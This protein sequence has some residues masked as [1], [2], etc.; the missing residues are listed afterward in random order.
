MSDDDH[1]ASGEEFLREQRA[2]SD[3]ELDAD[4][5]DE[6]LQSSSL[7]ERWNSEEQPY[8]RQCSIGSWVCA[9]ALRMFCCCCGLQNGQAFDNQHCRCAWNM[10]SEA[11]NHP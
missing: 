1:E 3:I 5:C 9:V 11:L 8:Q 6:E 7:I 10:G 2:A 4:M